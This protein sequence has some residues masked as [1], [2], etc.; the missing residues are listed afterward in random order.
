MSRWEG[1]GVGSGGGGYKAVGR[2]KQT[3]K[4]KGQCCAI[5][6]QPILAKLTGK[7]RSAIRISLAFHAVLLMPLRG[8]T[9]H[10]MHPRG[11]KVLVK[12][13]CKSRPVSS[14][15]CL[16]IMHECDFRLQAKNGF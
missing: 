6:R 15:W 10:K 11:L 9:G 12:A 7:A 3:F 2:L 5:S 1:G 8:H 14:A 16:W 13:T 4:P